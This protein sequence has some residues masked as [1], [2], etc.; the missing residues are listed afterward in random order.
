MAA[1]KKPLPALPRHI[2]PDKSFDAM[3]TWIHDELIVKKKAPG[4]VIGLS[5]TDSILVYLAC[6]K[7]FERAGHPEKV[8]GIHY[9]PPMPKD[10]EQQKFDDWWFQRDVL[11]WLRQQNP[12]S[13]IIVDSSINHKLDGHRWGALLDWSVVDDPNTGVLRPKDK[14][15]WVAGTRNATENVLKN[16]SNISVAASFQPIVHLWK[17]EVLD[18]CHHLG[19]PESAL[20]HSRLAD[21]ACG[22]FDLPALNIEDLDALLQI[23][24][25]LLSPS[26]AENISPDVKQQLEKFI[27]E[28][29]DKTGFKADIPYLPGPK[30]VVATPHPHQAQIEQVK[31]SIMNGDP[32]TKG[33]SVLTPFLLKDKQANA[34]CDLVCAPGKNRD[35]WLPEALTLFGTPG[36]RYKQKQRMFEKVFD[37]VSASTP[38]VG[39]FVKASSRMAQYG[40][41]FP[42][43]RFLTQKYAD[44]P[45]LVE[46]F[47]M[48]R[49]QRANDVRDPSLPFSDPNRDQFGPGF[50]WNDDQWYVEYRRG[51]I[52]CSNRGAD[53]PATVVIRNSSYF[54]GRDRMPAPV[55]V[56]W[57]SMKPEELQA[58][59]VNA[60][61]K[62]GKF[63]KWQN[64]FTAKPEINPMQKG[65]RVDAVLNYLDSFDN[66][67]TQW[68]QAKGPVPRTNNAGPDHS[69]T[70][71]K[72][73]LDGLVGMLRDKASKPGMKL[74]LGAT[75]THSAPWFPSQSIALTKTLVGKLEK[76]PEAVLKSLLAEP[77]SQLALMSGQHGDY[78]EPGDYRTKVRHEPRPKDHAHEGT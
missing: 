33:I 64:A 39:L 12:K 54:F 9:G 53:G 16:Y 35:A 11:P 63:V 38:A 5:G 10:P 45:A 4:F 20:R 13:P 27:T 62:S 57:E 14:S 68:L 37:T 74:Y 36:L 73:G 18:I 43:W 23:E 28:Q 67:L 50:V 65:K 70:G 22:R 34:A 48:T 19:V 58:L 52:V 1:S 59:D 61:E 7:A 24:A 75:P 77:G 69:K 26:Y 76:Q 60:L 25:G 72:G 15:Y 8:V 3:V 47:G 46:Q 66:N 29:Y 32:N 30:T 40:F 31:Q 78:P 55:Y 56:S 41:S 17:S 21:C 2:E 6:L 44:Q 42:R 49:L 71:E 51:Y